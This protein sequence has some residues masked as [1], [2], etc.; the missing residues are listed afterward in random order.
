MD[1]KTNFLSSETRRTLSMALVQCHFDYSCSSWYAVIYQA[2]KKQL[3]VPQYKTV[4]FIESIDPRTSIKQTELSSLGFL[5]GE[6]IVTQLPLNHD[7]KIFNNTCP[8][9][10]KNNLIK[11]NEHH[12]YNTKSSRFTY[13]T[14]KIM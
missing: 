14:A 3:Q 9:Y 2:L 6:N 11:I 12:Q 13:R 5:N 4:C 10:L 7:H 8:S 1:R